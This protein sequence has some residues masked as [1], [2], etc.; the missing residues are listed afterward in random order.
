M[1]ILSVKVKIGIGE[2]PSKPAALLAAESGLTVA[3]VKVAMKR[4]AVWLSRGESHKRIRRADTKLK[5]DDELA[6]YYN[7]AVLSQQ[8]KPCVLLSDEGD[9][10]LWFKPSGVLSQGSLWGDHTTINR[11]VEAY[12]TPPRPAFIVSRLDRAASGLMI[13][14][15]GKKAAGKLAALFE[16][17]D[18][19]KH[20]FAIVEGNACSLLGARLTQAIDDKEACSIVRS[21]SYNDKT[22]TSLIRVD[23]ETGRKHQIRKHLA[24]AGFPIV[25][26]RLHGR[27]VK[28]DQDLQLRCHSL[29]F[30]SPFTG[31]PQLFELPEGLQLKIEG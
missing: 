19:S 20:Y 6:L 14:A 25:G 12:F 18:I 29:S 26:D 28:G 9:F 21:C 7:K 10:S 11:F 31:L 3:E 4:G 15:H 16:I 1:S 17:K 2:Q 24:G 5:L 23:I 30:I 27:A 8:C 22:N 13:I